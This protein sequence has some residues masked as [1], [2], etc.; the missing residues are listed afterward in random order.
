MLL[1]WCVTMPLTV[2]KLQNMKD[3]RSSAA[4]TQGARLKEC[5]AEG[6]VIVA[7][8]SVTNKLSSTADLVVTVRFFGGGGDEIADPAAADIIG[9][10][11]GSTKEFSVR[12]G[13]LMSGTIVCKAEVHAR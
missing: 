13:S 12:R 4:V 9:I 2:Y 3:D 7:R 8:G 11:S 10:K 6:G 1:S 5:T